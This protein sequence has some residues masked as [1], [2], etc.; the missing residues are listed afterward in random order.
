MTVLSTTYKGD[1]TRT[2]CYDAIKKGR[3]E[4]WWVQRTRYNF[5]VERRIPFTV[6]S[7]ECDWDDYNNRYLPYA[8]LFL[9]DGVTR[10]ARVLAGLNP[11]DPR[12]LLFTRRRVEGTAA[13]P[14][15]GMGSTL[16][17]IA[18][19]T[20]PAGATFDASAWHNDF[21]YEFAPAKPD[22]TVA[23]GVIAPSQ[24]QQAALANLKAKRGYRRLEDVPEQEQVAML[25][26]L[27]AAE[28]RERE[29]GGGGGGGGGGDGSAAAG[30]VEGDSAGAGAEAGAA[31]TGA[32]AGDAW[33]AQD[34]R[35][36]ALLRESW[37]EASRSP[38]GEAMEAAEAARRKA[39]AEAGVD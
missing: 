1:Q 23:Q 17:P 9:A 10:R 27:R 18:A 26:Q 29:V 30:P 28:A 7:P 38:L 25:V 35:Y 5:V 12:N 6:I 13:F 2:L 37:R 24:A 15:V 31:G 14:G 20:Y 36:T 34:N 39:K 16:V 11:L 8:T 21:T 33:S 19:D 3:F 4:L 32:A 22:Y